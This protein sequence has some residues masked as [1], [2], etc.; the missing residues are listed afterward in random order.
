MSVIDWWGEA[1]ER[2]TAVAKPLLVTD[3]RVPEAAT[4]AEPWSIIC[5]GSARE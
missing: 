5:H 3:Q 1:P 2:P 4:C